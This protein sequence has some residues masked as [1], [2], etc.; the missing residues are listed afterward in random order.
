MVSGNVALYTRETEKKKKKKKK[1]K[2]EKRKYNKLM[3][4][5]TVA[6]FT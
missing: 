4:S 2:K 1:K 3:V 5:G 6:L